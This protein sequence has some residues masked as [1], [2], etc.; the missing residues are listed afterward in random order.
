MVPPSDYL[1]WQQ[2]WLPGL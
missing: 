2:S 1:A